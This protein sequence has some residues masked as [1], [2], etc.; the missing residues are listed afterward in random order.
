MKTVS[1]ADTLE[2]AADLIEPEGKW[3]QGKYARDAKGCEVGAV[4]EVREPVS[5]CMLGA[6]I[7]VA[8]SH[9]QASK[10]IDFLNTQMFSGLAWSWNDVEGRTQA[11]VVAELHKAAALAREQKL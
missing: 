6:I 9:R 11:E 5:F 3:T 4:S 1:V 2:L 8:G 10:P 7:H